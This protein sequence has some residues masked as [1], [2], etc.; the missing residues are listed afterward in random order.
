MLL[1]AQFDRRFK[2]YSDNGGQGSTVSIFGANGTT[3]DGYINALSSKIDE[4]TNEQPNS[5]V[6]L[7][8]GTFAQT[9][10]N[11]YLSFSNNLLM[12]ARF[13]FTAH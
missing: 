10:T 12:Q 13:I 6:Y 1:Q 3:K 4:F 5:R 7:G 9:T 8:D 11:S 2:L